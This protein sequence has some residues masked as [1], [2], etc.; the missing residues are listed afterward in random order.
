MC[1]VAWIRKVLL[2]NIDKEIV[3]NGWLVATNLVFI[4]SRMKEVD[5]GGRGWC[6]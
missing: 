3:V 4:A 6:S 1:N 2:Y 5:V